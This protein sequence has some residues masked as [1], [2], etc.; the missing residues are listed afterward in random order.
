M[1][2]NRRAP[3]PDQGGLKTHGVFPVS[4]DGVCGWLADGYHYPKDT[5]GST[6]ARNRLRA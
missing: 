6:E 5:W 4:S 3:R 2:L 1:V